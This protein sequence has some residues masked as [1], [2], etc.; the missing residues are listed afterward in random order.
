MIHR[1]QQTIQERA[2]FI[3]EQEGR[4]NGNAVAH[5]LRAEA[6]IK[7]EAAL[8]PAAPLSEKIRFKSGHDKHPRHLQPVA[9]R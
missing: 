1:K 2:F 9:P 8:G 6:Q 4:P 7:A 3:W 5:W